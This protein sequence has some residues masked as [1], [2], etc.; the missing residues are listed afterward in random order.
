MK[1]NFLIK[2]GGFSYRECFAVG[3]KLIKDLEE[4]LP[5]YTG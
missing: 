2:S 4:K 3:S 5:D 1:R